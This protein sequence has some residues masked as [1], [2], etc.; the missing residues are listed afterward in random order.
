M[1]RIHHWLCRSEM[2]R[3]KL[4]NDVIPWALRDVDLGE[5]LLELGPGPGLTT[6]ILRQRFASITSI[7][8]DP[9]LTTSLTSRF[10]GTN[11]EV[12]GG[13][14]AAMPFSDQSFSGVV[15]FTM[16]HHVPSPEL[17]D[18]LFREAHRVLK[19]RAN[20]VATDSR[21]SWSM[22]LFHIGDT[23]V[24]IDPNTIQSRLEKAGFREVFVELTPEMV[25]FRARRESRCGIEHHARA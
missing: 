20:F 16:L 18:Q 22:R 7:E 24:L 8:I 13:S 19:P 1:N 12:V 15:S 10:H 4:Q 9:K 5:R 6:H 3:R 25:R 2:W 14:A 11:V 21:S 23:M 17:Q